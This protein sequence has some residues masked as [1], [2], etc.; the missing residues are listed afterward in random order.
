MSF[1][2]HGFTNN[3][4]LATL[5]LYHHRLSRAFGVCREISALGSW[6]RIV[7][8]QADERDSRIIHSF[9]FD[10]IIDLFTKRVYTGHNYYCVYIQHRYRAVNNTTA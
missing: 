2:F 9:H 7:V 8:V 1:L 3:K 10:R 4:I 5:F 6:H